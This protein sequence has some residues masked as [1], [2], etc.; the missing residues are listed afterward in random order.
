MSF[1]IIGSGGVGQAHARAFTRKNIP[2]S[3][4]ARRAAEALAPQARHT[5]RERYS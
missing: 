5:H 3:V 1:A 2:V 4:A